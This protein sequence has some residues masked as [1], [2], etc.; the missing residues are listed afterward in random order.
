MSQKIEEKVGQVHTTAFLHLCLKWDLS[1]LAKKKK[2]PTQAGATLQ[3]YIL[4]YSWT[5]AFCGISERITAHKLSQT[6]G[7]QYLAQVIVEVCASSAQVPPKQRGVCGEN[8]AN[9]QL[10]QSGQNQPCPC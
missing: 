9:I 5:C 7:V 2:E 4:W 10:P 6:E 3:R 8:Q 1:Q